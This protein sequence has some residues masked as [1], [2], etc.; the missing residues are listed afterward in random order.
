[1]SLVGKLGECLAKLEK[2]Q[3]SMDTM[4]SAVSNGHLSLS[5]TLKDMTTGIESLSAGVN[6][7]TSQIGGLKGE[8]R[9]VRD[10]LK[11]S[12]QKKATR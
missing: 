4:G 11:W 7:H 8:M 9:Q 3:D 12:F 6:H 1:M 2:V 5:R 10:W